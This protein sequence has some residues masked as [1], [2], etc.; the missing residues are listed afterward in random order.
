MHVLLIADIEGIFGVYD[1]SNMEKSS[2]LYTQEIE[3]CIKALQANGVEKITV[4]DAHDAGN[5]IDPQITNIGTLDE[6]EVKLVSRVDGISFDSTYDFAIL[7]GFHGMSESRGILSHTLRYDFK[8]IAVINPQYSNAI[9]IGEVELYTRWLG[10]YGIPVVL[11]VGD[12]EATYEAN[13]FNPYRHTCCV[14]SY[15][16]VNSFDAESLYYKLSQSIYYAMKLDKKLCI[17]PDDSELL[18]EFYNADVAE[19][20]VARGYKKRGRQILFTNCAG[21][22]NEL[23]IL[24]EHLKQLNQEIWETNVAFL[25]DVRVLAQSLK[26]EDLEKSEVASLL[27]KNLLSLDQFSREK[28]MEKIQALKAAS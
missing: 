5:L 15:Y 2:R 17:S 19:S 8:E 24:I 3:V 1:F 26:R 18:I 28:I 9:P 16:Q 4:C 7:V 11:V 22:V 12:R 10:S 23:Y 13:C 6:H 25:K 14:K 27:E 21:L 20:L